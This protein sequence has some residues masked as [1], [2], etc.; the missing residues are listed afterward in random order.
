VRSI[1]VAIAITL[2]AGAC[3][4]K[5]ASSPP[6]A[7]GA[8]GSA[9]ASSAGEVRDAPPAAGTPADAATAAAAA[10]V[11]TCDAGDAAACVAEANKIAPQG[12]YRVNLSKEEADAKE[13]ATVKLGSR[14]CELGNGEG[15]ALV[16]RYGKFSDSDK[17]LARACELGYVPSC[18]SVGRGLVDGGKKADRARAAELLEKACDADVMDWMAMT[19]HHGGFCRVLQQ[20]YAETKDKAKEKSAHERACKQGDKLGCACKSDTDCGQVPDDQSGDYECY[21]GKCDITGGG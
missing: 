7:S 18:G 11:K 8:S 2:V 14:A 12:A 21:E 6:V 10:P 17:N 3:G 13:A 1:V 19:A 16:A 20:L 15:C 5:D 9:A 4:K